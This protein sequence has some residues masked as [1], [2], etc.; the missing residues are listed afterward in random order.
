M[1]EIGILPAGQGPDP[2][3]R[4]QKRQP[5]RCGK[6]VDGGGNCRDL[7]PFD[8]P[9]SFGKQKVQVAFGQIRD[10]QFRG[11]GRKRGRCGAARCRGLRCPLPP[12]GGAIIVVIIIIARRAPAGPAVIIII[13]VI[14]IVIVVVILRHRGAKRL[15]GQVRP[16]HSRRSKGESRPQQ[17]DKP[18]SRGESR[19][20]KPDAER[21]G[22]GI[23]T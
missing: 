14:I 10:H 18:N 21:E 1:V 9:E 11:E 23:R 4:R 7:P 3:A 5:R 20:A 13:I 17:K 2:I 16:E 6:A 15:P 8:Q 19:H 22:H 12:G